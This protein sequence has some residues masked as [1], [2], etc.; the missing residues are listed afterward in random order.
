MKP[1]TKKLILFS[2]AGFIAFAL[3]A[4]WYWQY[5]VSGLPSLEQLEN[6]K[7]ELATKVYS[8]DGEILDQFFY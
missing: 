2:F 6:P 5:L 4:F 7:P 1:F 8:V 3:F